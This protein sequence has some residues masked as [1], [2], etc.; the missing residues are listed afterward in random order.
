MKSS[1]TDVRRTH[2]KVMEGRGERPGSR[3]IY[4]RFPRA[5]EPPPY[6]ELAR[7]Q[8]PA[9]KRNVGRVGTVLRHRIRGH[10]AAGGAAES[11]DEARP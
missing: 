5:G 1:E 3:N 7:N 8:T 2:E 6:A 4:R 10:Q 11:K 9:R